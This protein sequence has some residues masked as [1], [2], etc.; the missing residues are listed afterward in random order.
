MVE[1][2]GAAGARCW[3]NGSCTF[4]PA[5]PA[6]APLDATGAGDTF[7]GAFLTGFLRGYPPEQCLKYGNTAARLVLDL[8]GTGF[9][10]G[11][12]SG[13]TADFVRNPQGQ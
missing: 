7:A 13:F 9:A 4:V 11:A 8:P 12:F 3:R 1:K 2:L 10:P 5:V 6:D